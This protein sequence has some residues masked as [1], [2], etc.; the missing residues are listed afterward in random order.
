MISHLEQLI[1][2]RQKEGII[3]LYPTLKNEGFL[4]IDDFTIY[5]QNS[6]N[7]SQ[8]EDETVQ[9]IFTSP[10]YWR[11]RDYGHEDQLGLSEFD[12][13][14][15]R[16]SVHFDECLR[17]LKP[18]GSLFVILGTRLRMD[19]IIHYLIYLDLR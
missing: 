18:E 9:T 13:F 10:S 3:D 1:T 19:N 4:S 14:V 15:K 5:Q 16:L 2:E 8:L 7:L 17:V 6:S 11:M 12:V